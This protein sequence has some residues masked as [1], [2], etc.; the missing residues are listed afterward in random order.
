MYLVPVIN[1]RYRYSPYCTFE[2]NE[3]F[4]LDSICARWK[5]AQCVDLILDFLELVGDPPGNKK[6][7]S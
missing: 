7:K 4:F 2:Q 1:Y 5:C 6:S 3:I